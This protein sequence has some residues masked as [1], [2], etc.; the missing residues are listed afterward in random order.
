MESSPL[1]IRSYSWL[2]RQP[3]LFMDSPH[4][5]PHAFPHASSF[6]F[7]HLRTGLVLVLPLDFGMPRKLSVVSITLLLSSWPVQCYAFSSGPYSRPYVFSTQLLLVCVRCLGAPLP[8]S[9]ARLP[10]PFTHL[11]TSASPRFTLSRCLLTTLPLTSC[12]PSVLAWFPPR[13]WPF[14]CSSF[15]THCVFVLCSLL[16]PAI[17]ACFHCIDIL[18]LHPLVRCVDGHPASRFSSES[19]LALGHA[20]RCLCYFYL[21]M[22]FLS[23]PLCSTSALVSRPPHQSHSSSPLPTVRSSYLPGSPSLTPLSFTPSSR[24]SFSRLAFFRTYGCR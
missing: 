19:D 18:S 21:P 24:C 16:V 11:L 8:P 3:S 5:S 4:F 1:S 17:S 14:S 23:A 22:A 12:T 6:V 9:G 2:L 7:T 10:A 13:A 20:A 15:S